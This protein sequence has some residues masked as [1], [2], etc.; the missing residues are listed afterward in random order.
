MFD[1]PKEEAVVAAIRETMDAAA[2]PGVVVAVG[3]SQGIEWQA[4]FG[5]R[6]NRSCRPLT[7]DTPF[8]IS[9]LSKPIIA[10]T[11]LLLHKQGLL[12]LGEIVAE[13]DL[14]ANES[15]L[16]EQRE[17]SLRTLLA[18]CSC[19]EPYIRRPRRLRDT[20]LRVHAMPDTVL[21][22]AVEARVDRRF[23]DLV[24]EVL[25]SLGMYHAPSYPWR[26]GECALPHLISPEPEESVD[27]VDP[28]ESEESEESEESVKIE[29][30]CADSLLH[31]WPESKLAQ[32]VWSSASNYCRF[33]CSMLSSVNPAALV[34]EVVHLRGL[35]E[36]VFE[37]N[38]W[39]SAGLGWLA[40][41]RNGR[42]VCG[43]FD[44]LPGWT[45]LA[46]MGEETAVVVMVNAEAAQGLCQHIARI[47][48]DETPSFFPW[49]L[50]PHHYV[51]ANGEAVHAFTEFGVTPEVWRN[52]KV[53]ASM[54]GLYHLERVHFP[55]F[56]Q[57]PEWI[58]LSVR[59]NW[60]EATSD[61]ELPPHPC[62]PLSESRFGSAFG[63]I[64]FGR[65]AQG[66]PASFDLG[67]SFSYV[68][69]SE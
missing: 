19:C 18:F 22:A 8:C 40:G 15:I 52:R 66:T 38:E 12:D 14:R 59:D 39:V 61:C 68:R 33:M 25:S 60:L 64:D 67:L 69:A 10:S 51:L 36:P 7:Q 62:S 3:G 34:P 32:Q 63:V 23:E 17:W 4:E 27:P 13:E 26:N 55:S 37:I 29:Y 30:Y 2:I 53:A 42:R 46:A 65:G 49:A 5:V 56:H 45:H 44:D 50:D 31:E 6:D 16:P 28:V 35:C 47:V 24:R 1:K 41:S 9:I 20:R 21:K 54:A 58:R 11:V 48:L 57:P 43:H